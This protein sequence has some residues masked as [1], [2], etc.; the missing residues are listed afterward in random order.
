MQLF[1]MF[2]LFSLRLGA[3]DGPPWVLRR[4]I[5]GRQLQRTISRVDHIVPGTAWHKNGIPRT[6][7]ALEVQIF[8]ATS[9]ADKRL[10]LFYADELIRVRVHF[11]ADLAAG[12]NT[13]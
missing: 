9:H 1:S 2:F 10:S 11:H 7:A 5:N 6:K 3:V 8:P 4:R 12:E 13:H